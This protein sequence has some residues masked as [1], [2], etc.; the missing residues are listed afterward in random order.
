[1]WGEIGNTTQD[2]IQFVLLVAGVLCVPLI[3]LPKPIIEILMH[4]NEH[5]A[6]QK[7]I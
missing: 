2:Q 1:M 4:K 7:K 6:E 5:H 3:L